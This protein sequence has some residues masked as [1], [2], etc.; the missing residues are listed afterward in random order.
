MLKAEL[1]I[2]AAVALVATRV[3]VSAAIQG[4]RGLDGLPRRNS[5]AQC[6]ALP[7]NRLTNAADALYIILR[8]VL[9]AI[10]VNPRDKSRVSFHMKGHQPLLAWISY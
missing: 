7:F 5:E 3:R 4:R 9:F 10:A 6:P 2:V 8:C 1:M